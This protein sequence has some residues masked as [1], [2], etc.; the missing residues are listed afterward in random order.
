MNMQY[1]I[2]EK[3]A[4]SPLS[5]AELVSALG[6]ASRSYVSKQ[7]SM[8]LADGVVERQRDGKKMI[9]SL[10]NG[11]TLLNLVFESTEFGE[12]ELLMRVRRNRLFNGNVGEAARSI[13][14]YAFTEMLNNAIEHSRSKK[15]WVKVEIIDDRLCF[16]VRDYGIGVFR[17]VKEEFKLN[18]EMDA[19]AEIMKGRNTTAPKA[20]SG[21]GIFFTSK[22][23][24]RFE[25]RSYAVNFLVDNTLPDTFVRS[26]DGEVQGTEVVFEI[27]IDSKKSIRE[28]FQSFSIDPEEGDFDRTEILV[29]LYKYGTIY[30]SR[31]QAR[32]MLL[33]LDKFKKIVLDFSGVED[34]GQAFADEVF[35]VYKLAHPEISVEYRNA[36][37]AVE[38]MIK[39]A[40]NGLEI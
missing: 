36:S 2:K 38:F 39:L 24:D 11:E 32:A 17:N 29:K 14:E 30:V 28:I 34:I 19:I 1:R 9:Y 35:R 40:K 16:M 15:I 6:V 26:I 25:I 21:M 10:R 4:Q 23:A 22:I 5:V 7:L 27:G 37:P 33:R 13:F 12:D 20:H 31:S 18:T 8:M 3:L